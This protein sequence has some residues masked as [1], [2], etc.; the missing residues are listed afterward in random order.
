EGFLRSA[1]A[2]IQTSGRAAR[3]AE[4][5]VIFY[6]DRITDSMRRAMDETERRREKQ[7]EHNAEH[8][9]EPRTILKDIHSPLVK[10]SQL[11]MYPAGG[12]RASLVAE[13]GHDDRPLREQIKDLEKRMREA[14]KNLEFEEAAMLRDRLKELREIQIYAAE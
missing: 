13:P 14:A 12:V 2:L 4:G 7:A 10:L 8:G 5:R 11:D 3:N 9:I 1:T 6:A